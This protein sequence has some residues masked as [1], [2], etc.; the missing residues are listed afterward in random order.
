MKP[1]FLLLILSMRFGLAALC[2]QKEP[3]WRAILRNQ[4]AMRE[5][6]GGLPCEDFIVRPDSRET[7]GHGIGANM[8]IH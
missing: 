8:A 3:F 5:K 4:K 7:E 2:G 6:K 1:S